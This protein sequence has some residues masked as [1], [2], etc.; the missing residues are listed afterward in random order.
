M[1]EAY[2]TPD[3]DFVERSFREM[4]RRPPDD[5]AR[6]RAVER[7]ADGTLSRATFLHELAT[8]PEAARVRELDDAVALG[9]GARARGARLAWLQAPAGT[10]ERVVEIPWVLSRL[11]PSG[12]VLEVGYAFAE[13]PYLAALLRSGVELVG[14][15]LAD[16]DVDGMERIVADVRSLPLPDGSV[17]Q[18]L[19]VSTLEHVGA[20][21][22]GTGCR[23]RSGRRRG[24]RPCASSDGCLRRLGGCS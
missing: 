13:A 7:L 14:V 17:D 23:S 20:D 8:A 15:D 6:R 5:D 4:L 19:L 1:L 2:E 21:N 16:R 18:V 3:E 24:Q 9:L 11:V 10:D 12:R 22:R